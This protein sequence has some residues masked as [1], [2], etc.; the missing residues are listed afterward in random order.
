MER[1]SSIRWDAERSSV[2]RATSLLALPQELT[3]G[4]DDPMRVRLILLASDIESR[5][6]LDALDARFPLAT[7]LGIVGSQ[8]PF[9]NGREHTLYAGSRIYDSGMVGLAFVSTEE[10]PLTPGADLAAGPQVS[11]GGLEAVSEVLRIERCKGNVVLQV[12]NGDAAHSLISSARRPR[13]DATEASSDDSRLY[14]RISLSREAAELPLLAPGSESVVF[15]VTGGDPRKG[16]LAIDTLR[17]IPQGSYIQ[18]L[19]PTPRQPKGGSA[20]EPSRGADSSD[21]TVKFGLSE[22]QN[23]CNS[24]NDC[25]QLPYTNLSAL[26]AFGATSEGGFVYRR[27][28][29]PSSSADGTPASNTVFSGS[30]ECAVP[31][32][33][34]TL[35]LRQPAI[36]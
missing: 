28:C 13:M 12:E 11:H 20:T 19:L 33:V 16:G 3:E 30:T 22:Y 25:S 2:T 35:K 9:L 21:V 31:G 34:V 8:T 6:T 29:Q 5:Q 14:A 24:S 15:Q 27:P 4:I 26:A 36:I 7:T 17:D 10:L 32:S 23:D 18:F 1:Q